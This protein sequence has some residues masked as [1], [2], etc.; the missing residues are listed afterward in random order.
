[1]KIL[2]KEIFNP[3]LTRNPLVLAKRPNTWLK[4]RL[5]ASF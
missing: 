4:N 5:S 3:Q 2:S 1:M